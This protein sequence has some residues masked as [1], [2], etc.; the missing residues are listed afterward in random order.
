M[1]ERMINKYILN[2]EVKL[3]YDEASDKYY[4]FLIESGEH[5]DLNRMGFTILNYLNQEK[6]LNELVANLSSQIKL[7][8]K[9][10]TTDIIDFLLLS[11]KNGIIACIKSN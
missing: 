2:K 6:T 9:T 7:N 10:V 11:E 4:A 1:L 3:K 5:F 8:K